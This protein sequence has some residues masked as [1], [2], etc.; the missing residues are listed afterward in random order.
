MIQPLFDHLSGIAAT[1]AAA[2]HLLLFLD[3]DGTLSPIV[4]EPE[5]AQLPLDTRN[6]L[7][8][9]ASREGVSLA[10][11]SGRPIYDLRERVGLKNLIYAGN[12]GLEISGPGMHFIE[13]AAAQR[14]K[15]LGELSRHL[16]TRLRHIPGAG[17]EYKVLSASV[18]F[19]KAPPDREEEIG[20]RVQTA[21]GSL[22]NLFEV[23]M[24]L[25]VFEIRP[26]VNWNKGMAVRWIKQAT[27]P[28]AL[29]IYIGDDTT[30]EDAFA[31]LPEGITISAGRAEK[32]S[33][34]YSLAGPDAV[35][36]FLVWLGEP[37]NWKE[38]G[39]PASPG[40]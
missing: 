31:A 5:R 16:R 18:H 27:T 14:I 32:T 37:G 20:E 40:L 29:P 28:D 2:R 19:R 21:V 30:D 34:R 26:K 9:L 35:Q 11:I 8:T 22:G 38:R 6:T 24:G 39:R 10:I 25:K 3:F 33:A 15:A 13:P 7:R 23:T 36:R 12:H 4:E 1:V 17:V